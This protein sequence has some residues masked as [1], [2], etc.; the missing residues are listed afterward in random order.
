M[1]Q[2]QETEIVTDNSEPQ[3]DSQEVALEDGDNI[4]DDRGRRTF[5]KRRGFTGGCGFI[6]LRQERVERQTRKRLSHDR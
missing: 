1:S 6:C 3:Q 2:D 5:L 4:L